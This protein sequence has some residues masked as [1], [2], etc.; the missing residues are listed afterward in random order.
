MASQF[1]SRWAGRFIG[2]AVAQGL[3]A[4]IVTVLI[5]EP[6]SFFNIKSYF[7]PSMVIAGGG[8]GTWLFTGYITYLVVGVVGVAVTA[9]F[10]FYIEGIQGKE[11]HGLTNYLAWGHYIFMNV[12][13]AASMLI[14]IYGGWE[15]G[16]AAASVSSGGLGLTAE[17]I[18]VKYLSQLVDPIGALAL[19]AALGAVLGGLGFVLRSRTP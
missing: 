18:H 2:A 13:A 8:G 14:M 16:Y 19:L 11:Y 10:Y 4:V 15:G 1:Q 7:S 3:I 12:G 9:V 17:Q 5:V 6:W